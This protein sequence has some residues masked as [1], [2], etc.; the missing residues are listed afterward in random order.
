M[1]E[2]LL[3]ASFLLYISSGYNICL[4]FFTPHWNLRLIRIFQSP[5]EFK[6]GPIYDWSLNSLSSLSSLPHRGTHLP[7]QQSSTKTK[8]D[9]LSIILSGGA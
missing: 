2:A 5:P 3:L 8:K 7:H 1:Q 6:T 9:D 4:I